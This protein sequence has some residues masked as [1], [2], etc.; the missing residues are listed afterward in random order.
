MHYHT[1]G[2][3]WG[4]WLRGFRHG[5]GIMR[6]PDGSIYEGAWYNDKRHGIGKLLWPDTIQNYD[7]KWD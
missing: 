4:E 2:F 7:G 5:Q 1:G 6:F 3:Y